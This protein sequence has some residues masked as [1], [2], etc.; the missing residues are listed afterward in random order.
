MSVVIITENALTLV[1]DEEAREASKASGCGE[2]I[3]ALPKGYETKVGSGGTRLSGGERQRT[4]IARA[5]LKE[6]PVIILDEA[7]AN[8]DPEN[9]DKLIAAFNALTEN[10][11]VIMIAHRLKTI[12]NADQIWAS[13]LYKVIMNILPVVITGVYPYMFQVEFTENGYIKAVHASVYGCYH[14]RC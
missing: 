10:K 8:V 13:F 12:R 4:A 11:T 6:A 7:T 9:E 14:E 2:F 1:S 5:M 3:R